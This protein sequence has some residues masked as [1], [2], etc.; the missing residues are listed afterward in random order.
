MPSIASV[1]LKT[2]STISQIIKNCYVVC[3]EADQEYLASKG[4]STSSNGSPKTTLLLPRV[5]IPWTSKWS[6]FLLFD[7]LECDFYTHKSTLAK[8]RRLS[9][10]RYT[11]RVLRGS[12]CL[13]FGGGTKGAEKHPRC[14]SV[15]TICRVL[16]ILRSMVWELGEIEHHYHHH[17]LWLGI[18]LG[19]DNFL[20]TRARKKTIFIWQVKKRNFATSKG[21]I[22]N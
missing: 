21:K 7:V 20:F 15:E 2:A 13:L 17:K 16:T 10:L 12:T 8:R 3:K 6:T 11:R 5:L 4:L 9:H 22:L 1:L 14:R 18:P 19:G